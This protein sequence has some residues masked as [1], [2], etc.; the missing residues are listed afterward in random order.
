MEHENLVVSA[1]DESP[2]SL[3]EVHDA[4]TAIYPELRRIA[5]NLM[6]K[7]RTFHTL[8]PTALANEA[9]QRLLRR[10]KAGE[11]PRALLYMGIREMCSILID[12]GRR[13]GIRKKWLELQ[14][15]EMLSKRTRLAELLQLS[16]LLDD[17]A[18]LDPRACTVL[19][20]RYF[21]G[22]KLI[23]TAK[24][25][26]LSPRTVSADWEFARSWLASRWMY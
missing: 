15:S 9:V 23:E 25:L 17:L 6:R 13:H 22:L 7:E 4:L 12:S 21:V 20:L 24:V 5:R 1:I 19:E 18:A 16:F 8:Q 3:D 26:G 2:E 14:S 10:E 11:D